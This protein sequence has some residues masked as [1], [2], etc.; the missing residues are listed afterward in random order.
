MNIVWSKPMCP[1]CDMAKNLLDSKGIEYEVR[2]LGEQWT[3]EQLLEACPGVRTVPQIF[4]DGQHIGTY[5]QLK[6]HFG[7]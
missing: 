1:Y 2:M 7:V 5:D 3:R 4:L 6:E